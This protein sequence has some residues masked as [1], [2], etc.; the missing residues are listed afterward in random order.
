M[1]LLQ[2]SSTC[3]PAASAIS[4]PLLGRCPAIVLCQAAAADGAPSSSSKPGEGA[5]ASKPPA[6]LATRPAAKVKKPRLPYLDSIR[7]FLIAYIGTGHF[8]AFASPS[9][10][11]NM[12]LSQINVVVGAFFVLSGYVA[13]YVATE[14]N[15]YKASPRV[16]PAAAY[17]VGR[18]AGAARC[19]GLGAGGRVVRVWRAG[20]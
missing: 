14:L 18:V 17:F 7:F 9:P 6:D 20:D 12:L 2:R 13:A 1:A 3:R 15:D 4:L 5:A 8:L 19:R 10:F 16:Q 11:V